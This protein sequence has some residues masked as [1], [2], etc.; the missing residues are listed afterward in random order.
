MKKLLTGII[1]SILT[2]SALFVSLSFITYKVNTYKLTKDNKTIIFQEMVHFGSDEYFKEINTEI[3]K[4]KGDNY[5]YYYELIKVESEEDKK[6]MINNLGLSEN[7]FATISKSTKL[8][9]QHSYMNIRDEDINADITAKQLNDNFKKVN[10]NNSTLI[11][12]N[13]LVNNVFSKVN[14]ESELSTIVSKNIMKLGLFIN[15]YFNIQDESLT[16]VIIEQRNDV[17]ISMIKNNGDNKIYVQYGKL[18]FKDFSN[19]MEANGYEIKLIDS[20]EVF[21]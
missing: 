21:K 19:K 20:K 2:M 3:A 17:L 13:K 4:Y 14:F 7:I 6:E 5:K 10:H 18:H 16:K 1:V 15:D 11:E 8:E 9:S 12:A